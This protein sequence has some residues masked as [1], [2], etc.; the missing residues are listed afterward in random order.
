M[1]G[2]IGFSFSFFFFNRVLIYI[3]LNGINIVDVCSIFKFNARNRQNFRIL[4]DAMCQ[5]HEAKSHKNV[6]VLFCNSLEQGNKMEQNEA[7][8][9][10]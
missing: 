5:Q 1:Y 4:S 2:L 9:L 10:S 6:A 3:N 7:F 8:F